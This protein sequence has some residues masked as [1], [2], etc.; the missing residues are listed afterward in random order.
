[1]ITGRF[2]APLRYGGVVAL[3]LALPLVGNPMPNGLL[4]AP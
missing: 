3:A 1:M 4:K 2:P